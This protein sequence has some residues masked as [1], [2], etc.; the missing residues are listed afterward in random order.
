MRTGGGILVALIAGATVG[1]CASAPAA[2]ARPA[3]WDRPT[4]DL[5]TL[6]LDPRTVRFVRTPGDMS[7][8]LA[9]GSLFVRHADRDAY[10]DALGLLVVVEGDA[11]TLVRNGP[12]RI[13]LEIDQGT[14]EADATPRGVLRSGD[15]RS[16]FLVAIPP[17]LLRALIE[18]RTVRGRIGPDMAF[19]LPPENRVI[20]R[21]FLARLPADAFG[22][23]PA[24]GR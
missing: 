4:S 21:D 20:F 23:S 12:A 14:F 10:D 1:G 6:T 19:V 17:D 16:S 7:A 5:A 3:H 9:I 11:A 15:Q 18:A 8:E 13:R 22:G 2:E 24:S